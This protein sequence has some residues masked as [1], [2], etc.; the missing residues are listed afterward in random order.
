[1]IS[2]AR[3]GLLKYKELVTK[4]YKFEEVNEAFNTLKEGKVVGRQVVLI[5]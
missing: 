4:R 5:T 2:L 3:K 1:V